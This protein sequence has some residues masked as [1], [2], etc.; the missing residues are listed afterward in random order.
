VK[1]P[2]SLFV[3]NVGEQEEKKV[4]CLWHQIGVIFDDKSQGLAQVGRGYL[5]IQ[6]DNNL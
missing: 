5:A 2:F 6:N 4:L 3:R 1:K